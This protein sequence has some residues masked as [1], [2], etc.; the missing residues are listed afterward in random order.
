M[1]SPDWP[2]VPGNVCS[3]NNSTVCWTTRSWSFLKDDASVRV[4]LTTRPLIRE[5]PSSDS[6]SANSLVLSTSGDW[7]IC[8]LAGWNA[9]LGCLDAF[10]TWKEAARSARGH[11][12]PCAALN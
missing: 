12:L 3:T 8:S 4:L 1:E 7:V 9:C 10:I 2:W 11:R 6:S 5:A